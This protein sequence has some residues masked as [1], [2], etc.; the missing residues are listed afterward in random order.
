MS[1]SLALI[2]KHPVGHIFA[3]YLLWNFTGMPDLYRVVQ[4]QFQM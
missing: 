1:D 3:A 2:E 4:I